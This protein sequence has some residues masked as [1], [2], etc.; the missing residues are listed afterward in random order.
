MCLR[1][2]H[3]FPKNSTEFV[4]NICECMKRIRS[5]GELTFAKFCINGLA[6][7]ALRCLND[8]EPNRDLNMFFCFPL[9]LESL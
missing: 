4:Y 6:F 9:T 7:Q 3:A 1:S 2:M 8:C 5:S